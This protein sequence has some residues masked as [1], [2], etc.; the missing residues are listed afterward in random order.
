MVLKFLTAYAASHSNAHVLMECPELLKTIW[1]L[2]F[3]VEKEKLADSSNALDLDDLM[4]V[5]VEESSIPKVYE[6]DEVT[7]SAT[8][9]CGLLQLST[10][11]MDVLSEIVLLETEKGEK[12]LQVKNLIEH[13][14]W[15]YQL[16]SD[17]EFQG[18]DET[19]GIISIRLENKEYG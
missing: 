11:S 12:E 8:E 10:F 15:N 13:Y 6:I 4:D 1:L 17:H 5:D 9:L 18:G 16:Q 2:H 3:P 14:S 7:T 19:G